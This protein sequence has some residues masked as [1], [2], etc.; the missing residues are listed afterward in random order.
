MYM[1]HIMY[2]RGAESE[3]RLAR[4]CCS[5]LQRQHSDTSKPRAWGCMRYD[6]RVTAHLKAL[7]VAEAAA[8]C[9]HHHQRLSCDGQPVLLCHCRCRFGVVGRV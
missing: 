6:P 3:R 8:L 7:C 5:A 4:T 1:L 2:M 9:R